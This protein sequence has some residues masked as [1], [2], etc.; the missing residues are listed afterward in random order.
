MTINWNTVQVGGASMKAYMGVPDHVKNPPGVVIAHHAPGLDGP[1]QD[2]VHR[3]M[4]AG[5]AAIAPDLF[6]RQA[7]GIDAV[8]RTKLLKDAEIMTDVNAAAAKLTEAGAAKLGVMGFCMGGRVSY[9]A[10]GSNPAFKAAAV[11]YGGNIMKA[12]GEGPSP[13]ERTASIACPVIGFF[14]IEDTN[15]SPDDVAKIG[16]ELTRLGKWHE[17]HMYRDAGHAFHNV[18]NPERYRH[19]AAHGSWAE[20]EAFFNLYLK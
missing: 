19:R 5:Y 9:L 4:R 8:E 3:L 13:F 11:F 16:A 2:A 12:L 6:H 20:L 14:G 15:P 10:A 7:T 17:F 1:I 18:T